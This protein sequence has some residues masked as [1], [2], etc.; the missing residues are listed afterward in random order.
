MV[1]QMW[2]AVVQANPD[3]K[4]ILPEVEASNTVLVPE[5]LDA[6]IQ[7]IDAIIQQLGQK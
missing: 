2:N 4:R 7:N 3:L 6:L 1:G 5:K